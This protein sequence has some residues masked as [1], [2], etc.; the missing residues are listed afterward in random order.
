MYAVIETGGK[1]YKVSEGDVLE[2]YFH[3]YEVTVTV[4]GQTDTELAGLEVLCYVCGDNSSRN[5]DYAT[6][7][8]DGKI[9]WEK[10]LG[11]DYLTGLSFDGL[12]SYGKV[13]A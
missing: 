6:V 4:L 7:G 12:Y 1:Q 10:T 3:P 11:Y 13:S 5:L 9:K 2:E 8:K